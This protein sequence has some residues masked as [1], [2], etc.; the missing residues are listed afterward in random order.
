VTKAIH[1]EG[2]KDAEFSQ[3]GSTKLLIFNPEGGL[4]GS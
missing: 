2:G 3:D 4:F 1:L